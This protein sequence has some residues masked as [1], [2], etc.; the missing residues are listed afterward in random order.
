[1]WLVLA[2]ALY[3]GAIYTGLQAHILLLSQFWGHG[4]L[5]YCIGFGCSVY[6]RHLFGSFLSS[7]PCV[8][9]GYRLEQFYNFTTFSIV[10]IAVADSGIP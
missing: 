6:M 5:Y 9:R 7:I 2:M 4:A 10:N 3:F 8:L 1:L